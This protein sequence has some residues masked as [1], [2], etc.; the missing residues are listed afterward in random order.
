VA[1]ECTWIKT[2]PPAEVWEFWQQEYPAMTTIEENIHLATQAGF[3]VFDTFVLPQSA[4][5]DEYLNPVSDRVQE[6]RNS[7]ELTPELSAVLD[8]TQR[9]IDICEQFGD[10]FGYVF[11]LMKKISTAG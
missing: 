9:E 11:Y 3:E 5:W 1:S 4:W 7:E 8:I 6:L 2:H 10:F